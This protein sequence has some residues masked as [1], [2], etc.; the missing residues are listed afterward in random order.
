MLYCVS[1]TYRAQR[2]GVHTPN[3][4]SRVEGSIREK[5]PNHVVFTCCELILNIRILPRNLRW[6]GTTRIGT[7]RCNTLQ[8]HTASNFTV[9]EYVEDEFVDPVSCHKDRLLVAQSLM[10]Q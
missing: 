5:E 9:S 1:C 10:W 7:G 3:I 8:V 6:F 4:H 2:D